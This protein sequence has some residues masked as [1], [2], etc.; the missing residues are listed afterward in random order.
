VPVSQ[1]V[2][3]ELVK[4]ASVKMGDPTYVE[5]MV[6]SWIAAQPYV[7]QYLAS[8]QAKLGG[9]EGVINVVFHAA[10]IATCYL[11]HSGRSVPLID[12]PALDRISRLDL[13]VELKKRQP[14]LEAYLGTNV[15]GDEP[16][17]VLI[18]LILAMDDLA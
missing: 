4:E 10:L 12:F 6:S 1:R 11:R 18:L 5:R 13:I 17:K 2:V 9:A 14:A 16:R 3:E 8:R 7:T 15:E